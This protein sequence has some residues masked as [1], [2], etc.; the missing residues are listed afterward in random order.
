MCLRFSRSAGRSRRCS[1]RACTASRASEQ[2]CARLP[3]SI[4]LRSPSSAKVAALSSLV[5]MPYL[6]SSPALAR[7]PSAHLLIIR[8]PALAVLLRT[9]VA[10]RGDALSSQTVRGWCLRARDYCCAC[11][12]ATRRL[13]RS[14]AS[15]AASRLVVLCG[16]REAWSDSSTFVIRK[17]AL[18]IITRSQTDSTLALMARASQ[19]TLRTVHSMHARP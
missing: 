9:A 12:S 16:R 14:S 6:V 18:S 15:R 2:G 10:R 1:S 4:K 17:R 3:D 13:R 7:P 11:K 5:A 8:H 19:G